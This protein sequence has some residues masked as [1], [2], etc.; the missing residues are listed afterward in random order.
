MN[1]QYTIADV[2]K[3]IKGQLETIPVN[4]KHIYTMAA[5]FN[6]IDAITQALKHKEKEVAT[7]G[8]TV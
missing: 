1:E 4:G 5:V 3:I 2:L 8:G 7:D 6:N